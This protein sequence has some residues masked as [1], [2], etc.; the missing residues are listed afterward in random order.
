MV[1]LTS[2]KKD[3]FLTALKVDR[4]HSAVFKSWILRRVAPVVSS[5]TVFTLTPSHDA[6]AAFRPTPTTVPSPSC[7]VNSSALITT[8]KFTFFSMSTDL[9]IKNHSG[10]QQMGRRWA[11]YFIINEENI[12]RSRTSLVVLGREKNIRVLCSSERRKVRTQS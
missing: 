7:P 11:K 1:V 8:A 10:K 9:V 12:N 2:A 3:A 6:H 5:Q 4:Q